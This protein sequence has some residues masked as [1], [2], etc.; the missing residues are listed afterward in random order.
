M[1]LSCTGNEL[2][3]IPTINCTDTVG[4]LDNFCKLI[5]VNDQVLLYE[6]PNRAYYWVS[7]QADEI[8]LVVCHL[9][10]YAEQ[11]AKRGDWCGRLSDY[12]IVG[13]N[14]EDGDCYILIVELRHTLSKVEQA[15][16]KFEQLEN[17]IEQVMSRLQ[18]DVI[19][20]SLFE[21]ACWQPDKYK[22]A[23]FVIA[24]AGVRSIP[25]KQRTRRIVK[26]NYKGIIKI[27]P[28]ERVKECKITW[29]E[30]LNEIVPKCDPH[31]FKGHRKQP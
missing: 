22:I 19:S 9:E 21:K 30:L 24:P 26:D 13:M 12:L 28:H 7:L 4:Q 6:Q 2:P 31:R 5:K 18:T 15:I 3:N 17:S 23:G 10:K 8:Q 1:R 29:T 16:D 14:T 27:M 25:L 20:S 11:A